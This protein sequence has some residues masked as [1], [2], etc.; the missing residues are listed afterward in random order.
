[1]D[2]ERLCTRELNLKKTSAHGRTIERI[3]WERISKSHILR[4]VNFF[5]ICEVGQLSILKAL[6]HYVLFH[7]RFLFFLRFSRVFPHVFLSFLLTNLTRTQPQRK[8]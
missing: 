8:V 4:T 3:C 5:Y 2:K 6:L 7:S 1:M